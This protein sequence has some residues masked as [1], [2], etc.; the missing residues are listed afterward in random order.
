VFGA[1]S[2]TTVAVAP[3]AIKALRPYESDSFS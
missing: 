2:A 3:G 1:A